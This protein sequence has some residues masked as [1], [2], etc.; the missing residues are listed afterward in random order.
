MLNVLSLFA[1]E[2]CEY[3]LCRT[4]RPTLTFGTGLSVLWLGLAYHGLSTF[5]TG[6]SVLWLGLVYHGL[7]IC[8]CGRMKR[9]IAVKPQESSITKTSTRARMRSI[10]ER[11]CQLSSRQARIDENIA[12]RPSVAYAPQASDLFKFWHLF[13][14]F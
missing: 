5:G 9:G 12:K 7:S 11:M 14:Y 8:Q 6:L 13:E 10:F 1:I 2:G 3:Q 4:E